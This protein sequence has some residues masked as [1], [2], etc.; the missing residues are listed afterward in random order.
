MPI[1][2]SAVVSSVQ[3]ALNGTTYGP[4]SQAELAQGVVVRN[5]LATAGAAYNLSANDGPNNTSAYATGVQAWANVGTPA[6]T[7]ATP[8]ASSGWT[9]LDR[10]CRAIYK[11]VPLGSSAYLYDPTLLLAYFG[12]PGVG[13]WA[14]STGYVPSFSSV[15][16]PVP[17]GFNYVCTVFGVSGKSPP[18]FPTFVGGTC[19]DGTSAWECISQITGST[20]GQ[21]VAL[22]FDIT[23]QTLIS[24]YGRTTAALLLSQNSPGLYALLTS[25]IVTMNAVIAAKPAANPTADALSL[26]VVNA[27]NVAI[28]NANQWIAAAAVT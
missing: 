16:P 17:N 3:A 22:P 27:V 7:P 14:A 21:P 20:G 6:A 19:F 24:L 26:T 8:S 28:T 2:W 1:N 11:L 18:P 13:T 4:L 23:N 9:E 12:M 25:A 15:I 10:I 5:A